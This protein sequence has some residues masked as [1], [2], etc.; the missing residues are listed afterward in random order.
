MCVTA[1]D[2][3][4]TFDSLV[5]GEAAHETRRSISDLSDDGI[6]DT[7]VSVRLTRAA[8]IVVEESP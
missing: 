3:V 5:A 7:F 6:D 4:A 8:M 1:E 2:K